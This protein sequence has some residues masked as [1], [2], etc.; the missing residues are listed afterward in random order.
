[1]ISR[2]RAAGPWLS[3]APRQEGAQQQVGELGVLGHQ[4]AELGRWNPVHAT[5]LDHAR[6][7]VGRLSRQQAQLTDEGARAMADQRRLGG[8]AGRRAH[9]L[10]RSAFDNDQVVA[11]IAGR[12]HR[13][14]DL[15][16]FGAAVGTKA[17]QLLLAQLRV[18]GGPA[19]RTFI[20]PR[21]RC[22]AVGHLAHASTIAG[23]PGLL[24]TAPPR[25]AP[26]G[27]AGAPSRRGGSPT[28]PPVPSVEL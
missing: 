17:L 12:E 4:A 14:A 2:P 8:V 6:G 18:G 15:D 13:V 3:L 11:W 26:L 1:M 5:G 19:R 23:A 10:D 21:A 20:T 22:R 28:G 27:S 24:G 25:A 16:R 9:H 7:Q